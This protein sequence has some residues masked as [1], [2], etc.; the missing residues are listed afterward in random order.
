MVV[1]LVGCLKI[2][3]LGEFLRNGEVTRSLQ[4]V[5]GDQGFSP[6]A[7]IVGNRSAAVIV[8]QERAY[9][10]TIDRYSRLHASWRRQ[11]PGAP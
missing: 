4:G 5:P 3:G 1:I 10:N 9:R 7:P 6:G 2:Q 8:G 11:T